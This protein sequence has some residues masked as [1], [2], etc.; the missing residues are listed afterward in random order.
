VLSGAALFEI[1]RFLTTVYYCR[2]HSWLA[3]VRATEIPEYFS[4][5][6]LFL[7]FV[8]SSDPQ[9]KIPVWGQHNVMLP[10]HASFYIRRHNA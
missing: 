2:P 7:R 3:T 6:A 10:Q 1:L 9:R 8:F 4:H 5:S